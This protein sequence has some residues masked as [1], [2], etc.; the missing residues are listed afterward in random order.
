[1]DGDLADM[2]TTLPADIETEALDLSQ[3]T[4]E[5]QAARQGRA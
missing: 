4:S 2:T 3:N 5:W 1:M